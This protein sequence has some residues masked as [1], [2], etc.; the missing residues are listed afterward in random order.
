MNVI[1]RNVI[2]RPH[3]ASSEMDLIFIEGF[4]GETVIGIDADELH[5]RQPVRID[6]WAG[7][8][9]SHACDTDRIGD[10][11]DYSK[12]HAALESLLAA[13]KMQL[14]EALAESVAQMLLVDFG[15]HWVRVSLAKPNKFS[16]VKA[17][18]VTIER[19]VRWP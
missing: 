8:P 16:N 3:L 15:A 4:E 1:D 2:E 10:T 19:T 6:L 11:I 13:H 14:L 17:V 18:G 9:H 12:V 7:V 5:D